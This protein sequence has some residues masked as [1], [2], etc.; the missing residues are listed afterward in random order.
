MLLPP[1][2]FLVVFK[3]F[4]FIFYWKKFLF[5]VLNSSTDLTAKATKFVTIIL[6]TYIFFL[7]SLCLPLLYLWTIDHSFLPHVSKFSPLRQLQ[8]VSSLSQANLRFF[9]STFFIKLKSLLSGWPC[10]LF[11]WLQTCQPF[12][13]TYKEVKYSFS[14][15]SKPCFVS[16]LKRIINN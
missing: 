1:S 7:L 15:T 3:A 11:K 13:L 10:S 14:K 2:S 9:F 8:F 6:A 5:L 4:T 12:F 16:C